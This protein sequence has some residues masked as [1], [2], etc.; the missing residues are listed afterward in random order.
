M[1]SFIDYLIEAK[2]GK[3]GV[4]AFGRMNPPTVGHETVVNKTKEV[5]A[6]HSADHRIVLSGSHDP[7][8]NPLSPSKKLKHAKRAFPNTNIVSATEKSPTILHHAAEMHR[9]GVDHLHVVGGSDRNEEYR[10]LLHKFN[11]K[12]LEHGRY[13]FKSIT[14]HTAGDKRKKNAKG[15]AGVS[16]TSQRAHALAG[17]RAEFNL[18]LPATMKRKHKAELYHDLRRAMG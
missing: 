6:R 14:T 13:K 17:K 2:R 8:K 1:N 3:H 16:G 15:V 4:L 11:G 9:Q 7:D 10:K 5:A 12:K 18:G